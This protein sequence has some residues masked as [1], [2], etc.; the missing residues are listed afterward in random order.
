M[1]GR[2]YREVSGKSREAGYYMAFRTQIAEAPE[3]PGAMATCG[4]PCDAATTPSRTDITMFADFGL[5]F[6]H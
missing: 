3:Q 6:G 5:H 1:V 4:G 2:G